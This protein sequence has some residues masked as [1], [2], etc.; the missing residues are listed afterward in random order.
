VVF[1]LFKTAM[2]EHI[3]EVFH[4]PLEKLDRWSGLAAALGGALF[5]YSIVFEQNT[6]DFYRFLLILLPLALFW[7]IALTGLYRRLPV[8]SQPGNKVTLGLAL[9]SLLLIVIGVSLLT[10]EADYAWI[11][12][13]IGFYGLVLAIAGMGI[14]TIVRRVLGIWRFVPLA[15][16]GVFLGFI[17]SGSEADILDNPVQLAFIILTGLGW[18]LLG[19]GLWMQPEDVSGTALT[20]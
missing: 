7:A 8:D 11:M 5:V 13:M 2:A 16:A 6:S 14:I 1:D 12:L 20:A 19:I 9:M 4:M 10:P 15:L 3:W 17:L 18:L